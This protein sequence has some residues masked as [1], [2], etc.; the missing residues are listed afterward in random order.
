MTDAAQPPT[1]IDLALNPS[2][3]APWFKDPTTWSAWFTFLR[4]LF[5]LP[6]GADELPLFRECTGLDAPS[7]NGVNE[8]WLVCGRR[9]GKSLTLALIAVFLACFRDWSEYLSPGERGTVRH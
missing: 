4:V 8:A 2:C 9:A 5:G 6:L 7:A 1:V 3:F